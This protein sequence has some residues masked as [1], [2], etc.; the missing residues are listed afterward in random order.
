MSSTDMSRF[1]D[2][3]TKIRLQI[4][5]TMVD[6]DLSPPRVIIGDMQ[7]KPR[8]IGALEVNHE[9]RIEAF[10]RRSDLKSFLCYQTHGFR[11]PGP[12]HP[13]KVWFSPEA[14]V[15]VI[16]PVH[17]F[18]LGAWHISK[19]KSSVQTIA[20]PQSK[21]GIGDIDRCYGQH[22]SDLR[23]ASKFTSVKTLVILRDDPTQ[24]VIPHL[25]IL[26]PAIRSACDDIR[27]SIELIPLSEG[28]KQAFGFGLQW[29]NTFVPPIRQ[30]KGPKWQVPA[31]KWGC[32]V[33]H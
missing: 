4:W 29:C 26:S 31:M 6:H 9:S 15:F 12:C 28:E 11:P 21:F 22:L 33:R 7:W 17:G 19:L 18:T 10:R 30:K 16:E 20:I 25:D 32:L 2:L 3:P 5:R 13:S 8:A 27:V 24:K 14:D 23:V 1:A